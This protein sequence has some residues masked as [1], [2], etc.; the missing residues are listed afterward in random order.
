M[1]LQANYCA[2]YIYKKYTLQ[3]TPRPI[4][5]QKWTNLNTNNF[6]PFLTNFFWIP[7]P[8]TI[9]SL[10]L[11]ILKMFGRFFTNFFGL[12][13]RPHKLLVQMGLVQMTHQSKWGQSNW[14]QVYQHQGQSNLGSPNGGGPMKNNIH[15]WCTE[16]F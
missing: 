11:T 12:S 14:G 6:G 8:R 9:F 7:P 2:K 15:I 5:S 3:N 10:Y 13:P 1:C 4:V 16:Q